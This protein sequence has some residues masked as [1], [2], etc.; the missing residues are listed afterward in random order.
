M[1]FKALSPRLSK[2]SRSSSRRR[3]RF[4]PRV[5]RLEDRLLL[6]ISMTAREQLLLDLIN[7]ARIDP[8]GTAAAYG[9]DLNEGLAPG[10]ISAD[11][12]QPLAPRQALVNAAG[13]HS[14]DMLDNDY[15]SHT[16]LSG[17]G[18]S[19]RATA[20]GY[21]PAAVGENIG[22]RGSTGPIDEEAHVYLIHEDLFVDAGVDGR[23]HRLNLLN[24]DYREV[25]PGVRYG[26]YTSGGTDYNVGM[27]TELF[28][29]RGGNHFLTG[30]AFDDLNGNERYEPGEGLEGVTIT[31]GALTNTTGPSGGWVLEV[32]DGQYLVTASGGSFSGVGSLEATVSGANVELDFVS[33]V[34]SGYVNYVLAEVPDV[35]LGLITFNTLPDQ[36][37][38]AG[39]IGYVC[40]TAR[41]G[42]LTIEAGYDSG[43]GS[44]QLALCDEGGSQLAV[45]TLVDGNQRIDWDV[46]AGQ[47]Y[48]VR[49][50]G[51]SDAVELRLVNLVQPSGDG[52]EVC[53]YG[54]DGD[55]TFVSVA[56]TV[57]SSWEIT[58]NGV[59]YDTTAWPSLESFS[60]LGGAG[61]DTAI[62]TGSDG[63]DVASLDPT[64]GT[65]TGPGYA[66]TISDVE[67]I[68]VRSGGGTDVAYLRGDPDQSDS[69]RG[70]PELARVW[71]PQYENRVESFRYVHGYGT[72]GNAD[73]AYLHGD[74]GASDTFEAW[75]EMA[76]LY[77]AGFYNR[78]KSFRH[79][80]GYGTPE[81]SDVAYL[82]DDPGGDD[83]FEAWPEMA[84]LY[85][86]GFYNR[87]KSF[88]Y[89]H[90]YSTSGSDLAE[91]YDAALET[92]H[93]S[94]P[95]AS[96]VAWL[97]AFAQIR[98]IDTESGDDTTFAAPDE[99]L[100]AYWE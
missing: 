19:D 40:Q 11:A 21:P 86:A 46:S 42:I 72:P 18:P 79:V 26:V 52:T 99:L 45:S 95:A 91:L 96:V 97:D 48:R 53:V 73:V 14:Q 6:S 61:N 15:F 60:L 98:Q 24:E 75:P 5:E 93:T 3:S 38:S 8:A 77:G 44:A 35:E 81:G 50:S 4:L 17:E 80:H 37:P 76:R 68:T 20:A 56:A 82:H 22:L 87:V 47:T 83:T 30:I 88:R 63:D 27:V 28:G 33:G 64:S 39:Q 62:H 89:V 69:F 41:D 58:V 55:D 43:A 70:S 29:D 1:F 78:V 23:G 10:T 25:G 31:T 74:P 92:G 54:T 34:A 59:A 9:I 65:I 32:P 84:R 12:K 85:G 67:T 66:V 57:G 71:G 2:A 100:T 7:R 13:L 94:P 49:L 36:D 51:T 16:N 90:G